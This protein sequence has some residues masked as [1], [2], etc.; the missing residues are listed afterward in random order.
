MC[1]TCVGWLELV[2]YIALCARLDYI[3]YL[4]GFRLTEDFPRDK[5]SKPY[6]RYLNRLLRTLMV[7]FV[8]TRPLD[9]SNFPSPMFKS[10]PDNASGP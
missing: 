6:L 7:F 5:K 10:R 8:K 9:V 3:A 1:Y 2:V 4:D